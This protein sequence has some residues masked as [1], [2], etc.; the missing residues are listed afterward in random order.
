MQHTGSSSMPRPS[1]SEHRGK[2]RLRKDRKP[3]FIWQGGKVFVT[4]GHHI[5]HSIPVTD[6]TWGDREERRSEV[7]GQRPKIKLQGGA[8]GGSIHQAGPH[9]DPVSAGSVVEE[10]ESTELTWHRGRDKLGRHEE[11]SRW[12]VFSFV[13]C[14]SFVTMPFIVL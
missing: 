12:V 13:R 4:G 5:P 3:V 8:G 2:P 14:A 11:T 10:R 9:Y 1:V 7:G 6:M